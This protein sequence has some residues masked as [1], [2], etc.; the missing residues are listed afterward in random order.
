MRCKD[1]LG[2]LYFERV[3]KGF[4]AKPFLTLLFVS[5]AVV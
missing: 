1:C 2:K 5:T 3:C 4:D